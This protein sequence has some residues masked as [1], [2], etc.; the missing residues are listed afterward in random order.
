MEKNIFKHKSY[1][2]IDK[3]FDVNLIVNKIKDKKYVISHG[4]YPFISYTIV[5][6]KYCDEID[7][8]TMHH[9]KYKNRPIKY[10]S[11]VDR[12]IYQCYSYI[13]NNVYNMYCVEENINDSAIAYRTNLG[14]QTNIEFS[15]QVFDF[16]KKCGECYILVSDFSS[17]FD[18]ID[19]NL[20]KINLCK[21]LKKEKLDE[22]WYKVYKSM[23]NYSFIEKDEIINYLLKNKIETKYSIKSNNSL[24]ENKPW[25]EA[26][27]DLKEKIIKNKENYGI[28]QGS[29]LSGIFANVYMIDFD[30]RINDYVKGKNGI[31]KRYSD[32]LI[33]IIPKNNILSIT[34]IWNYL[35]K[36]KLNY[37]TLIMNESKTSIY[38]YENK[39]IISLHKCIDGVKNGGSFVS[40]LGFSF[41]GM[42]VRFR[43]KT[44]TKFYYKLYRKIDNMMERENN[45]INV[46]KKRKSKIDKHRIL[47]I[48]NRNNKTRKFID[49]V[50][51]AKKVYSNEK[52]IIN[53]EKNVKNKIFIRFNKKI[54]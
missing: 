49:Y 25:K 28:P 30:K 17:F 7:E 53:F 36:V 24:F 45:R 14:G 27:K 42:Y 9:W 26:K 44:L 11:H 34:E 54:K 19:H 10:A 50:L 32:D 12:Y 22:D 46:G 16:I 43:D 23:T 5:T 51:R 40:F 15:K 33:I 2:H 6:K 18:N 20:L 3:P 21:V 39:K 29:P 31:Y 37:P 52:Y 1:M 13:L 38:L 4:F 41:D 47:K 48:L 35:K 8:E